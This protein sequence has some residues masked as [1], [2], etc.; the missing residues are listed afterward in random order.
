ME[1]SHE[2]SILIRFGG[3]LLFMF[4]SLGAFAWFGWSLFQT[5]TQI[6]SNNPVI[7]FNKGAL[8][9]LGVGIG[10]STL[11]YIALYEA[12][13]RLPLTNKVNKR[14]NGGALI[15]IITMI[16]FPQVIH[17]PVERFLEG[18]GY[19]ICEPVSYQWFMYRK[20][21]YVSNSEACAELVERKN[22]RITEGI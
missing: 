1:N 2:P 20:I 8:Y 17:Y 21:I 22:N 10:L 6:A 13:L 18:R 4:L 19:N 7:L 3:F 14:I 15:S 9:M 5:I 12:I 11:T 16:I